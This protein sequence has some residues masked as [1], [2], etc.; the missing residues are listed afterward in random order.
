MLKS[1]ML[2]PEFHPDCRSVVSM[3]FIGIRKSAA[4]RSHQR[5]TGSVLDVVRNDSTQA[6]LVRVIR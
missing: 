5:S 6:E 1:V 3:S 4:K 2:S